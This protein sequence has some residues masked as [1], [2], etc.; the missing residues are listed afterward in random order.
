M[1]TLTVVGDDFMLDGHPTR[2]LSG[3]I[4]YFRVLPEQWQDRLLKL[5]AMGLNTVETYV[6]WN[7]HEPRPGE[8]DFSGGLDLA[9]FVRLAQRLGLRVIVRPGPYICAEW[10]FGGL[11]AW[12]L[13]DP[14]MVLR[15]SYAPYLAA[16]RR[17]FEA[18]LPP[19]LPLQIEQGGAIIAMQVENEYGSYGSDK[20]YLAWLEAE[21]RRLGVS[22]LLFTSDGPTDHMLMHG[23]LPH[24]LK[25]GN[26]GS[27]ADSEFAKLREYQ[28]QGPLLCMEFWNGWFDHWGEPHHTRDAADAAASLDDILRIGGHVNIFM[29]HGGTSFGFM[30]GANTD[31]DSGIYQPTVNSYDYDAPLAED[32]SITPKYLAMREVL[33]RYQTEVPPELPDEAPRFALPPLLLTEQARLFD[34]LDFDARGVRAS[35]PRSMESLGQAYGFL[36]YRTQVQHPAGPTLL[37]AQAV[38]DRAQVF[39]DGRPVGVLERDRGLSLEIDWPGGEVCLELLVEN[40]GRVNYGPYLH[41]RKGLLGWVRLGINLLQD[42]SHLPLPLDPLPALAFSSCAEPGDTPTVLR[43]SFEVTQPGDSFVRILGG[44]KG[45]VWLNGFNLGRYWER[46]PQI[47]LYVPWPLLKPGRNELLVLELEPRGP[48]AA[49]FTERSA[50]PR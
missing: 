18:L 1:S 11:P 33:S 28:P 35:A 36:L 19:L 34:A 5:K 16:V 46:G 8:F 47:D 29:F 32:G 17:F 12:L 40:L 44:C 7:L 37:T 39:V 14:D 22:G 50:N 15:S 9:A 13:A 41:D 42:W 25:T 24:L 48:V 6:A 30:N 23:T 49:Q 2:V 31:R 45:Q 43:S 38:H 21:L 10:E 20:P 4:H 26:F 3:A 27:R